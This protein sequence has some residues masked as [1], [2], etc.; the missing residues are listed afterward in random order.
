MAAWRRPPICESIPKQ[1]LFR[2]QPIIAVGATLCA[3][4]P[5]TTRRCSPRVPRRRV[6]CPRGAIQQ[7]LGHAEETGERPPSRRVFSFRRWTDQLEPSRPA[8]V[9]GPSGRC[10]IAVGVD[11]PDRS[12]TTVRCSCSCLWVAASGAGSLRL[13]RT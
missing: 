10:G 13:S 12:W 4:L 6:G 7:S 11:N 9:A 8:T 2:R 1:P 5:R 3:A